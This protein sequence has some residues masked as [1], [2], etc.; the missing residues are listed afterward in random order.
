M[1]ALGK[2][3]VPVLATFAVLAAIKAFPVI[4]PAR[5]VPQIWPRA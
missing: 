4:N 1:K 3:V 2:F 5:Y